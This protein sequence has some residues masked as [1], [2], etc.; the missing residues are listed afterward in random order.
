MNLHIDLY[1]KKDTVPESSKLITCS[2][3]VDMM[4]IPEAYARNCIT[5]FYESYECKQVLKAELKYLHNEVAIE[6]HLIPY[7]LGYLYK[8]FEMMDIDFTYP[9]SNYFANAQA[10][11]DWYKQA[12]DEVFHEVKSFPDSGYISKSHLVDILQSELVLL[13][14]NEYINRKMVVLR[15]FENFYPL[16]VSYEG[17]TYFTE[18]ATYALFKSKPKAMYFLEH[19]WQTVKVKEEQENATDKTIKDIANKMFEILDLLI[20]LKSNSINE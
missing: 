12:V 9:L 15:Y 1:I 17:Q 5:S 16:C 3:L 8:N 2:K 4:E 19:Y 13:S 6:K 14:V 10:N 20:Q 7:F 18:E 11:L